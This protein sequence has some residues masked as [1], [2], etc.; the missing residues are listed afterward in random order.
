MEYEKPIIKHDGHG[1]MVMFVIGKCDS[2]EQEIDN[3]KD[4]FIKDREGKIYH[5]N[6]KC[7][8]G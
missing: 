8:K 2:C 4:P 6:D 5:A 3:S 1:N 7:Y